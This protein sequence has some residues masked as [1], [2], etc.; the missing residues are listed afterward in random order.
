VLFQHERFGKAEAGERCS[1]KLQEGITDTRFRRSLLAQPC[2]RFQ[3]T[4]QS[5]RKLTH[6]I[7]RLKFCHRWLGAKI[8]AICPKAQ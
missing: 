8:L 5:L 7:H 2:Q 1:Q 4:P 6:D 3:V